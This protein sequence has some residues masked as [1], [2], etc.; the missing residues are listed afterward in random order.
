M[1]PSIIHKVSNIIFSKFYSYTPA[2]SFKR[3]YDDIGPSWTIWGTFLFTLIMKCLLSPISH[4]RYTLTGCANLWGL[5]EAG[6]GELHLL[7]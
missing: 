2:S 7:Q 5:L 3:S 6:D 1:A 4:G